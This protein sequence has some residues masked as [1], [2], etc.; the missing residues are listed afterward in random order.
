MSLFEKSLTLKCFI[1][2]WFT[3][4]F[5]F[6]KLLLSFLEFFSELWC[7]WGLRNSFI[8]FFN[9]FKDCLFLFLKFLEL[10]LK[11]FNFS[12]FTGYILII[13]NIFKLSFLISDCALNLTDSYNL[14]NNKGFFKFDFLRLLVV[15]KLNSI[16]FLF[17]V[18][19]KILQLFD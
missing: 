19:E 7:H 8:L 12:L 1:L 4:L 3:L 17:G 10:S 16:L 11:Y 2:K 5:N 13:I 14:L 18:A 9:N 6:L 15:I